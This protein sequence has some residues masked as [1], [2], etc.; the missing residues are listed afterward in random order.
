MRLRVE[1][2]ALVRVRIETRRAF[3]NPVGRLHGGFLMAFVDQCLF[4]APAA[5]RIPVI[6]GATVDVSTQFL[7]PGEV[8]KPLDAAVEL[9][10]E[11]GRMLFLRG[12]LE[13]E[14]EAKL[15]FSGTLRKP[16]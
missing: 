2:P 5:L 1:G 8:G 15:A 3:A 16:R 14:G 4:M 7:A 10:R 11:T 12:L 6:G 13:Q 9:L